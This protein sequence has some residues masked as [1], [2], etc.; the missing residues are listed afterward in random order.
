MA[1]S[2]VVLTEGAEALR[3]HAAASRV[4][5]LA[6]HLGSAAAPGPSRAKS[7]T[8]AGAPP[9]FDDV[10][11]IAAV[12]TPIGKAR[13]GAFKDTT[14]DVLLATVLKEAQSRSG[15]PM[16]A[17]G[18]ICVGNVQHP[19]AGAD[20]SRLAQLQAGFPASVPIHAV[21]RQCSSGL[22]AVM[23]V[24]NAIRSGDIDAGIGAG[25]ES[26]SQTKQEAPVVDWGAVGECA[27]ATAATTAMG[28]TSETVAERYGISREKQDA[29]AAESQRRAAA[30]RRAGLFKDEIVPVV[31]AEGEEP[32]DKDDGIREGTTAEGLARL[33]PAFKEDGT[34]TAG[35]SSQVSD[36]AAAVVLIRRDA[37][38]R[39]GLRT[40]VLGI[41]RTFCVVGVAPDEM[42]VGPAYAVPPALSRAG[43]TKDEVDV[44]EINEAFA[45]QYAYCVEALGLDPAKVNPLGGA[46]ALGHPLG[47]TGARQVAT[48]LHQLKRTGGRYGVVSMCIGTGMG[49]AAV[50]EAPRRDA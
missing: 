2:R 14:P 44:Y 3:A 24:A 8:Q 20:M 41:V 43:L 27:L 5:A 36:G 25:V 34:T 50:F 38:H 47:C 1:E 13:R 21:N 15:V 48:L 42:G 9:S 31:P 11:I 30:A 7:T 29:Y 16:H 4:E 6:R 23:H 19:G 49:A 18:D 37:Y 39:L 12:R 40:E 28:T 22:Q 10:L 32:V 46:I 33:R 17:I 45:S 35:N 26:M